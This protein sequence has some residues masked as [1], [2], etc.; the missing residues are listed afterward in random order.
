MADAIMIYGWIHTTF[1]GFWVGL[2]A[3]NAKGWQHYLFLWVLSLGWPV[4]VAW[5]LLCKRKEKH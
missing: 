5:K 3:E 4:I 1:F 2:A